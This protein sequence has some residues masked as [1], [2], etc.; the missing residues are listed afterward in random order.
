VEND[1]NGDDEREPSPF[2]R[3]VVQALALN[4]LWNASTNG[5]AHTK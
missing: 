5:V 3:W 1:M 4:V 2:T